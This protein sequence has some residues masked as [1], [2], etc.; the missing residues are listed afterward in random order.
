MSVSC[1]DVATCIEHDCKLCVARICIAGVLAG[2]QALAR[3]SR[4]SCAG[5]LPCTVA[6]VHAFGEL[7][8]MDAGALFCHAV[9]IGDPPLWGMQRKVY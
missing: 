1:R 3:G 5:S 8:G 7:I 4:F 9:H 2:Q 6:L